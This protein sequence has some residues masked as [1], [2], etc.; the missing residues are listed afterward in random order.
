MRHRVSGKHLG[1]TPSHR[2]AL[3]RN[4]A[5]S[6]FEHGAIRT[7]EAKAKD[8]RRFVEKLITIA[9]R[10]DLHARRLVI[11]RLQDRKIVDS[12][13]QEADQTIV[14][15]LFDE[16][17][18]RYRNRAGGYTRIIRLPDRRIGD[19][20]RQVLLQLVEDQAAEGSGQRH[21]TSRRR[22]Q[23]AK[24]IQ[25]GAQALRGKSKA[26]Q[27]D[28][29]APDDEQ[30]ADDDERAAE[31]AGDQAVAVEAPAEGDQQAAEEDQ[32]DQAPDE[33]AQ[34]ED[35]AGDQGQGD[36]EAGEEDQADQAPDKQSQDDDEAGDQ[37]EGKE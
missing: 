24:R 17:A 23:A 13:G 19:A 5:A 34:D 36:Q 2:V 16:I 33:Q 25:A 11:S 15:K 3:R 21:G 30:I 28:D 18:P 31:A 20:G 35:E 10:G 27:A 9:R 12:E 37:D 7:T 14:Q 8:V 32:A 6:L 29:Q 4:L 26:A 1:R 22:A